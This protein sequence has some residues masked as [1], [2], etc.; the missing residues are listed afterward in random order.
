MQQLNIEIVGIKVRDERHLNINKMKKDTITVNGKKIPILVNC[1]TFVTIINDLNI[2]IVVG[3]KSTSI[4][5][6]GLLGVD[7]YIYERSKSGRSD[8]VMQSFYKYL[9]V[10]HNVEELKENILGNNPYS[11]GYSVND[12][13]DVNGIFTQEGIFQKLEE[14]VETVVKL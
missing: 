2:D 13:I 12:L 14:V 3:G 4:M 10:S 5:E 11:D 8:Q 9:N 1:G 7:Y 6:I